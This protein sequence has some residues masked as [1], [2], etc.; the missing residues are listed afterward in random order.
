MMT[1][2]KFDRWACL[3]PATV[4]IASPSC[5]V[6]VWR[7]G[8]GSAMSVKWALR[9][10]LFLVFVALLIGSRCKATIITFDDLVDTGGGTLITNPYQGL[11][12]SNFAVGNAVL[13]T[14]YNGLSGYYYGM[15]TPSNVAL[16]AHG[17]PAEIDATG[18]NFNFFGAY[19]TA[20]WNSNLNIEV[21]GFSGATLL[22]DTTVVASATSPTLFAF[23]YLNIGRLTF[24]SFGGQYAGFGSSGEEFAMDNF[25]FDFVPEPSAFLLTTAGALTLWA[26]LK[27]KRA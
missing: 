24:N 22:Y 27:R 12:W 20:A 21:Q 7:N 14:T 6:G 16:N 4:E 11:V 5:Y 13:Q 15:I 10:I 19:L 23:N 17:N 3:P 2:T 8:R 1:N 18:T 25:D 26:F 9:V